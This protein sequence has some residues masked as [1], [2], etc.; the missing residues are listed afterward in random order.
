VPWWSFTKACYAAAGPVLVERGKFDLDA[1][2]AGQPFMLRQLIQRT[3]GL[4][5]CAR[6]RAYHEAVARGDPP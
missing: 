6:L 2:I 3:S 4:R 1:P 5:C